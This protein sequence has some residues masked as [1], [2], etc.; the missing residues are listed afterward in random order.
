M[1]SEGDPELTM[2][3]NEELRINKPEEQSNS[4]WFP[5]PENPGTIEDHTPKKKNII[6]DCMSC[7]KR[8]TEPK[9]LML[10]QEA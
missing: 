6:Y 4:L 10:D 8:I 1:I 5:T 2:Y 7:R 3:L 9:K